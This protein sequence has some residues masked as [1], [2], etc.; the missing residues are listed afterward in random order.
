M[1]KREPQIIL[2]A[3]ERKVVL[4]R[5]RL[6]IT[7]R[8]T[9]LDENRVFPEGD[10][11]ESLWSPVVCSAQ[12]PGAGAEPSIA[13]LPDR[14]G[15]VSRRCDGVT[16]ASATP[17]H[18][19]TPRQAMVSLM[20]RSAAAT[21]ASGSAARTSHELLDRQIEVLGLAAAWAGKREP[22]V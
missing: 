1:A 12:G 21:A 3:D 10:K 9:A 2:K 6:R 20:K 11:L 15:T 14:G 7:A 16:S 18:L 19:S 17:F 22:L 5:P 8:S 13:L 4:T